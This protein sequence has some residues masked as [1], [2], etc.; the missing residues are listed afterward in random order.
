MC[1]S[2]ST[3]LRL[4][5][6]RNRGS[7]CCERAGSRSAMRYSSKS[8]ESSGC[9]A[10][11]PGTS[12]P[13]LRGR[14]RLSATDPSSEIAQVMRAHLRQIAYAARSAGLSSYSSLTLRIAEHLEANLK[15]GLLPPKDVA[16][17]TA[18]AD[19]SNGYLNRADYCRHALNLVD[20]LGAEFTGQSG[21]MERDCLLR[22]LLSEQ[23]RLTESRRSESGRSNA[24]SNHDP[25]DEEWER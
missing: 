23:N 19:A 25:N 4:V 21:R 16:L 22:G 5:R 7:A 11:T 2:L 14:S 1:T 17:V 12:L 6:R 8:G 20:L 18:W 24:F 10:C 9:A 3:G 15:L 13:G